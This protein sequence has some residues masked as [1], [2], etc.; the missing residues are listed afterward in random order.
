MYEQGKVE[1]A[2]LVEVHGG[3]VV[4]FVFEAAL[5]AKVRVG[6]E[7]AEVHRAVPCRRGFVAG[8]EEF[9]DA[10]L[11]EIDEH[12]IIGG[13]TRNGG[14]DEI[15]GLRVFQLAVERGEGVE[16][17]GCACQR[18]E[19]EAGLADHEQAI[20]EQMAFISGE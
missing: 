15:G 20:T 13:Q 3:V 7:D 10:A 2:V 16:L 6:F 19:F 14:G 4:G 5:A 18:R 8:L 12:E 1:F 17:H 9:E 11:G